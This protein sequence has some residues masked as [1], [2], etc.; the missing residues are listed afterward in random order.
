MQP[1]QTESYDPTKGFVKKFQE[2]EESGEYTCADKSG[3]YI[4]YIE[5]SVHEGQCE[6]N[7]CSLRNKTNI[8]VLNQIKWS[9]SSPILSTSTAAEITTITTIA[10]NKNSPSI[11]DMNANGVGSRG[12]KIVAGVF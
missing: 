12:T 7:E 9:T 5:I 4:E 11:N 10:T 1:L 6:L 2:I 8:M 3:S